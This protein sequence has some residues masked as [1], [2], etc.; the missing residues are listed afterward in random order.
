MDVFE[1][2]RQILCDQLDLPEED[3][4]METDII[5]DLDADSLDVVD[6]IMTIEDD[7]DIEVDDEVIEEFNTIADV[8]AY[9]EKS[10]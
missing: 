3:I 5:E 7:F 8:V 9:I 6:M 4:T 10:L 1:R 2:V